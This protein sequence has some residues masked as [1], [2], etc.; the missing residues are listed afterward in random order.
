MLQAVDGTLIKTEPDLQIDDVNNCGQE[1]NSNSLHGQ[2]MCFC[3]YCHEMFEFKDYIAHSQLKHSAR[4]LAQ[5]NLP[6]LDAINC[7]FC[8]RQF[9]SKS[10]WKLH[11][12]MQHIG[13]KEFICDICD[14]R[15]VL[16]T[17]LRNHMTKHSGEKPFKCLHC[18]K[19][20]RLSSD[21]GR[22]M[23]I[24]GERERKYACP[25]CA[26]TFFLRK[27]YRY[28]VETH[29]PNRE[30]AFH[31]EICSGQFF[32]MSFLRTHMVSHIE[33]RNFH[34]RKCEQ[35]FKTEKH[36]KHH[37]KIVHEKPLERTLEC[38]MC[39][40]KF[41]HNVNLQAHIKKSHLAEKQFVCDVCGKAFRRSDHCEVHKR[42]H[43]KDRPFKCQYCQKR[44]N[45]LPDM[46]AHERVHT[47]EKPFGCQYCEKTFTR[48]N[49]RN[50]HERLHTGEKP[51]QCPFDCEKSFRLSQAL[52]FHI[53]SKHTNEKNFKCQF[54]DW[55]FVT[56]HHLDRHMK[57]HSIEMKGKN[58][59]KGTNKKTKGKQVK[60]GIGLDSNER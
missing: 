3:F 35:S 56:K 42:L 18:E 10:E 52:K 21:R 26:R 34:C 2:R 12:K 33:E 49:D 29:N 30:R 31:C 55:A 51:H 50:K 17:T 9:K 6:K 19:T 59:K 43:T 24:H 23:A 41:Y 39:Q 8:Q 25:I 44:F 20:F 4:Q 53:K 57:K 38:Y 36:L 46:Q 45:Q 32:T 16:K 13:E 5:K 11:E 37:A 27:S 7:N 40:K 47:G 58:V 48:S 14:C 22:H 15:F 28:H 60:K 1:N 54:C